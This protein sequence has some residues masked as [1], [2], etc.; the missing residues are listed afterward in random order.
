VSRSLAN[1]WKYAD[2]LIKYIRSKFF[3]FGK[4]EGN[5]NF[6]NLTF[7]GNLIN[8][9]FGLPPYIL[10][11]I[12]VIC[13]YLLIRAVVSLVSAQAKSAAGA[14]IIIILVFFVCIAGLYLFSNMPNIL[15]ALDKLYYP[16]LHF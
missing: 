13:G 7:V 1:N 12:L 3:V 11:P 2:F 16:M 8:F 10:V 9:L 5:M 15:R 14:L 6:P 4:M